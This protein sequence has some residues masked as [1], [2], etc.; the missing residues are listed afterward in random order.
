MIYLVASVI[1]V[2]EPCPGD[3]VDDAFFDDGRRDGNT[4]YN[5]DE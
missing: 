1:L 3:K 4:V 2:S 5:R